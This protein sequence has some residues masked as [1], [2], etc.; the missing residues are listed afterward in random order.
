MMGIQHIMTIIAIG[1]RSTNAYVHSAH[2]GCCDDTI[3]VS[4][5]PSVYCLECEQLSMP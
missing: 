1:S 2:D 4:A 3:D 5:V